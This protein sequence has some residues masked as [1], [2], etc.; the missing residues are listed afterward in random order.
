MPPK[1]KFNEDHIFTALGVVV[2]VIVSFIMKEAE[3]HKVSLIR[4]FLLICLF[5]VSNTMILGQ[6]RKRKI[7]GMDRVRLLS[8]VTVIFSSL[9][10]IASNWEILGV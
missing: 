4:D 8:A 6:L 10:I 1:K 9:I 7:I 5:I 2:L 3:L